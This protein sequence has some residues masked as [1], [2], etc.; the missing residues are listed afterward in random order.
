MSNINREIF[1][2]EKEKHSFSLSW[3]FKTS[4]MQSLAFLLSAPM[5][6][7]A[8]LLARNIRVPVI[9]L[10]RPS[11]IENNSNRRCRNLY[12]PPMLPATSDR[13]RVDRKFNCVT[14][15]RLIHGSA[16]PSDPLAWQ[17]LVITGRCGEPLIP[18]TI[19]FQRC[20]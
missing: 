20:T 3:K 17:Q 13:V 16:F 18:G 9:D 8:G 19:C 12:P 2:S 6:G 7:R 11:L 10:N 5:R 1:G 4:A 14:R 15:Q